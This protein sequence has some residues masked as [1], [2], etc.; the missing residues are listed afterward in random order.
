MKNFTFIM[1]L[2]FLM[3]FTAYSQMVDVIKIETNSSRQTLSFIGEIKYTTTSIIQKQDD[4]FAINV[5]VHYRALSGKISRLSYTYDIVDASFEQYGNDLYI[6]KNGQK[7]HIAHHEWYYSP[8]WRVSESD[9]YLVELKSNIEFITRKKILLNPE[10][11]IY[12]R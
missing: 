8:E 9:Q 3:P 11:L 2:I 5:A 1:S 12:L 10:I 6:L 4:T 7:Y